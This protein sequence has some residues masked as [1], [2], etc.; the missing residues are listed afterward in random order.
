MTDAQ[1]DLTLHVNLQAI[2]DI[3]HVLLKRR[4]QP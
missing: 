1:W 3:T 2:D 4:P